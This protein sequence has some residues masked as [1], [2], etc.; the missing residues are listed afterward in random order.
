ML[1][2]LLSLKQLIFDKRENNIAFFAIDIKQK[3]PRFLAGVFYSIYS[4]S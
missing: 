4:E 2:Q 3:P 1:F